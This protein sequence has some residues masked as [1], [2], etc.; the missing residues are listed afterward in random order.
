MDDVGIA[1][2]GCDPG[3]LICAEA[4]AGLYAQEQICSNESDSWIV[5]VHNAANEEVYSV[6]ALS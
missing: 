4:I 1:L 6:E 3:H 5:K 2:C